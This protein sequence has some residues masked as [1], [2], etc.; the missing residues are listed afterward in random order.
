MAQ[1]CRMVQWIQLCPLLFVRPS[2]HL[3]VTLFSQ[4][5]SISFFWFFAWSSSSTNIKR[6]WS[7]FLMK[8]LFFPKDRVN[9]TFLGPNWILELFSKFIHWIFLKLYLMT[10]IKKWVRVEV[11]FMP[12][13]GQMGNF[14][15]QNQPFWTFLISFH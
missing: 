9:G 3:P 7:P 11:P 4:N 12:K 6:R 14:W 8:N 2:N 5:W 13:M 15:G 10:N 1:P